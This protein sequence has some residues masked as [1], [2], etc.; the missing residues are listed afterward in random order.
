MKSIGLIG[1]AFS[2][3]ALAQQPPLEVKGVILGA[4][5]AE[6]LQKMPGASCYSE[7]TCTWRTDDIA[8]QRCGQIG[9]PASQAQ[10]DCHVQLGAELAF[11]PARAAQFYVRLLHERV[12]EIAVRFR[13]EKLAE[14]II[15]L[16]E[17][18]GPPGQDV[19]SE[20][21]NR[22]GAKFANR[23]AT[24]VMPDGRIQAEQRGL[25]TDTAQVLFTAEWYRDAKVKEMETKAKASAKGL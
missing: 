21:Q 14:V 10:L 5:K 2:A 17:K 22:L 24:W 7:A 3:I 9:F 23:I 8:R 16:S 20:V 15:A 1:L 6:M 4:T 25:D 11:G 19:T 12:G 18:Y 13:Q